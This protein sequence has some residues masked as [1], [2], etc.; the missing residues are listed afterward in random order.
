MEMVHDLKG[1]QPTALSLLV[2]GIGGHCCSVEQ[3]VLLHRELKV[4][5]LGIKL[6]VFVPPP[7]NQGLLELVVPS[8]N[9]DLG[10][11]RETVLL[12]VELPFRGVSHVVGIFVFLEE[13]SSH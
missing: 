8:A 11:F 2:L 3:V 1:I 4:E 9:E 6:R 5:D 7:I 13:G 12:P 10:A